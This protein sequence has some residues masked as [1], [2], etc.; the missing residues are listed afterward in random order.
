[1]SKKVKDTEINRSF[2]MLCA[3]LADHNDESPASI[4]V[5]LRE[6]GY[7]EETR[8]WRAA[9]DAHRRWEERQQ[10]ETVI[11]CPHVTLREYID[12]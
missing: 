9:W 7:A 1:M 12:G 5:E 2:S 4:A 6:G 8:V 11:L 3:L 10:M